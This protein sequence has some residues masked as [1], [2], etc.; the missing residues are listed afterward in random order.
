MLYF[1][2]KEILTIIIYD[3][4]HLCFMNDNY[5]CRLIFIIVTIFNND[6][7]FIE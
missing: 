2:F 1:F 3:I 4:I 7:L 6:I 5:F